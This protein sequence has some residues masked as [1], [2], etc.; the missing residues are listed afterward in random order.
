M[1]KLVNLTY[2]QK[3][4][5]LTEQFYKNTAVNNICGTAIIDSVLDFDALN[6][7]GGIYRRLG[8]YNEA[9]AVLDRA[10]E[11]EPNNIQV[12][13]NLGFTYKQ[14]EMFHDAID[15]LNTV[16]DA[17]PN[18]ILSYNH[19]GSIHSLLNDSKN[20]IDTYNPVGERDGN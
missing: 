16:I 1:K 8:K 4:I 18:D 9:L 6:N 13:Y 14:L 19:L 17:N 12:F 10:L 7:L 3:A 15:C 11:L 2:P 20:D 5:L